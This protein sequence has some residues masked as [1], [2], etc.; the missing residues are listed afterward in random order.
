LYIKER[1]QHR[2]RISR[3]AEDLAAAGKSERMRIARELHDSVCQW[4]AI[5]KHSFERAFEPGVAAD[6]GHVQHL[7]KGLGYLEEG[8]REIRRISHDLK[9]ALPGDQPF[10]DALA[11]LARDFAERT[12]VDLHVDGLDAGKAEKLAPHTQLALYR[13]AQEALMNIEKHA[14]ASQIVL[15]LKEEELKGHLT[16]EILDNGRGIQRARAC[17]GARRGIGVSN[18][19]ERVSEVGGALTL[20]SSTQG[21]EV[22]ASVPT[23]RNPAAI[24]IDKAF[25]RRRH[26]DAGHISAR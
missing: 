3:A 16:L 23:L 14:E 22:I 17:N 12:K 8:I 10:V 1:R 11:H 7:R 9:P 4:L 26:G 20:R 19:R 2:E 25:L 13:T 15:T 5:S 21:T 24:V 6:P 18:M